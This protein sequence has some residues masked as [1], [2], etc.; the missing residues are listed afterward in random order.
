MSFWFSVMLLLHLRNKQTNKR[1]LIKCALPYTD[2][3]LHVS[4]G[5]ATTIV[6]VLHKNTDKIQQLPK[7]RK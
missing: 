2:I 4:I 5:F 1:T 7:L 3:Y 6:T